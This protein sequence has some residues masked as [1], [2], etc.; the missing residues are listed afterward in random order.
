VLLLK[1][2]L[3][4]RGLFPEFRTLESYAP[5]ALPDYA[6]LI[7]D[8]ALDFLLG[9]HEGG[10]VDLGAAWYELTGL[11]FVYAVWALRRG[12]ENA[13]LRRKLRDAWRL[14][15]ETL[16]AIIE[17]RTE[18]TLDFRRDYLGWHVHY[19][20]G[21]DERRGIL[22]FMELLRKHGFGPVFDPRY[23]P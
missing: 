9:P 6:L 8:P 10:V 2:L 12:V 18:Y 11:P 23:L 3:A 16:D 5:A 21:S 15:L 20:L 13:E 14:G 19:H 17:L 7:G 22:R 4:E 1:V